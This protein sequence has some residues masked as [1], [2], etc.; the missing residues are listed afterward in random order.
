MRRLYRIALNREADAEGLEYWKTKLVN[1]EASGA[2]TAYGFIFSEE[3]AGQGLDDEA[4]IKL[5]Y[6]TLFDREMD[7]DGK[8]TWMS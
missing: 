6:R 2:E 7:E 3:C 5:L 1:N 8:S 4:F